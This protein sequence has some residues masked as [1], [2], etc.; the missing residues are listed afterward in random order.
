MVSVVPEKYSFLEG[1][2]IDIAITIAISTKLQK[3]IGIVIGD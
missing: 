2:I 3:F 1:K